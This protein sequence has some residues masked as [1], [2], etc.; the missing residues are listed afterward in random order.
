M[1]IKWQSHR[2][3]YIEP[4]QKPFPYEKAIQIDFEFVI[5]YNK[6]NWIYSNIRPG[7]NAG[8]PVVVDLRVIYYRPDGTIFI[9]QIMM[10]GQ[11]YLLGLKNWILLITQHY[12]LHQF[13]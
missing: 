3:S 4:G 6:S 11:S 10:I 5:D 9:K 8:N 7:R 12:I 2:S 1:S 13:P